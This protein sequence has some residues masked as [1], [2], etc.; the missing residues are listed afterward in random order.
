MLLF[1]KFI[2]EVQKSNIYQLGNSIIAQIIMV[3]RIYLIAI[4]KIGLVVQVTSIILILQSLLT[5]E[6]KL[7]YKG[8]ITLVAYIDFET[9]APT[10]NVLILKTGKYLLL[11]TL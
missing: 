1:K 3:A 5:F 7:K 8:D 2:M 6:K 11:H 4:L 9:L 10:T